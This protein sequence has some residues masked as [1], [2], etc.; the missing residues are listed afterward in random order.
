[1]AQIR[2]SPENVK[3]VLATAKLST[4]CRMSNDPLWRKIVSVDDKIHGDIHLAD[5]LDTS[6]RATS[7]MYVKMNPDP[8]QILFCNIAEVPLVGPALT[9]AQELFQKLFD[10]KQE[11]LGITKSISSI[12]HLDKESYKECLFGMYQA[13]AV[14]TKRIGVTD[15]KA[16]YDWFVSQGCSLTTTAVAIALCDEIYS[17][18]RAMVT[19]T[20]L[21]QV[22][23]SG[24]DDWERRFKL[25]DLI[26]ED[27]NKPHTA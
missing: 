12:K 9:P 10:L 1:M 20:M 14:P 25:I 8:S 19:K 5:P 7:I 11:M 21:F 6:G 2:M 3:R 15:N 13:L 24:Y 23:Q 16:A 18:W 4:H 17:H 26:M 22:K 27:L